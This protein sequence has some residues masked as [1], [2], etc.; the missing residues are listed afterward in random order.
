VRLLA[1]GESWKRSVDQRADGG[2]ARRAA[3]QDD[4]VDLFG[5]DACVGQRLLAG[6]GG[7]GDDRLR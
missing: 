3:D 5:R 2:D 4:F 1:A 7:A 6:A